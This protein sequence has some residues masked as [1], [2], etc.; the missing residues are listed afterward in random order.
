MGKK[1]MGMDGIIR[2]V[3]EET[4]LGQILE[5]SNTLG[6]CE[7]DIKVHDELAP[8]ELELDPAVP[9]HLPLPPEE[10]E[11]RDALENE[12]EDLESW[13]DPSVKE[14]SLDQEPVKESHETDSA[15]FGYQENVKFR[16][17]DASSNAVVI[18]SQ[19]EPTIGFSA[20]DGP[21]PPVK[22]VSLEQ[23]PLTESNETDSAKFGYQ[24]NVNFRKLDASS[25]AAVIAPQLEPTDPFVRQVSLEQEPVKENK[26]T[27][28]AKFGYQG[29]VEFRKIDASSNTAVIIATQLDPTICERVLSVKDRPEASEKVVVIDDS[30]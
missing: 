16:K 12:G 21:D 25:N 10:Q 9:L 1:H 22:K 2:D 7:K 28:L 15:K 11:P 26:E 18:A 13:G 8:E 14:V 3:L 30:A 27:D 4:N 29:N 5:G 23:E 24:G 17:L 6:S 20:E 19:L